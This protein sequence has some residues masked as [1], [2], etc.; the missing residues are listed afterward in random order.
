MLPIDNHYPSMEESRTWL[1]ILGRYQLTNAQ[2]SLHLYERVKGEQ[3]GYKLT[4]IQPEVTS[5]LDRWINV[6]RAA[7]QPVAPTSQSAGSPAQP[8]DVIWARIDLKP[9]MPGRLLQTMYKPPPIALRVR[10]LSGRVAEYRLLPDVARGGF[11][12]S[13]LITDHMGFAFLTATNWRELLHDDA[14]A[15]ILVSGGEDADFG[16]FY[17]PEFTASFSQLI[18]PQRNISS[19]PGID[20]FVQFRDILR[21]MTVVEATVQP[22]LRTASG[23]LLLLVVPGKVRIVLPSR[24]QAKELRLRFGLLAANGAP[25]AMDAVDF[26]VYA[27][28]PAATSN[29]AITGPAT[30]ASAAT[31][32]ATTEPVPTALTGT[33]IWRRVLNPAQNAADRGIHQETVVIPDPHPLRILIE[34]ETL[35]K[36]NTTAPFWSGI[37]MK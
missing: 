12:L 10:T 26:R 19:V 29:P 36:G 22:Q 23:G 13:P 14:V 3:A 25:A 18:F 9:K 15:Q 32:P 33:P 35:T 6:P 5:L 16:A 27:V 21:E 7:F 8:Q 31:A 24:P 28:N 37:E 20:D 1:E 30:N 4:P 11:L 34:T 2:G 17:E